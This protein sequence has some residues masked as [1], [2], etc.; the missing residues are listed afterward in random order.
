MEE[1]RK[2][3][4]Q[5]EAPCSKRTGSESPKENERKI[6]FAGIP[7]GELDENA[8]ENVLGGIGRKQVQREALRRIPC[9][10]VLSR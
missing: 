7:E 9:G 4:V 2:E 1:K 6:A 10:P 5:E 3:L 8:L